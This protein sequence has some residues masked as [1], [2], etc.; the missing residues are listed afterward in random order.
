[1]PA[2]NSI[3]PDKLARLT[4]TPGA[5]LLVDVRDEVG[6]SLIPGSIV[7]SASDVATWS[8]ILIGRPSVIVDSDGGAIAQGIA[9]WLRSEGAESEAIDGGFTAWEAAGFPLVAVDRLPPR[10]IA[11]RTIWVTRARPKVDRIACPW[12]VRRFVDPDA[13]FLFV[14]PGEVL[15]VAERFGAVPFDVSAEGVFWSHRGEQCTFDVMIEEFGLAGIAPLVHLAT[16]VRGA[17]TDRLDIVPEAAGLLAIS[18]GLSRMYADDLEQLD[19]GMLV[20]DALYRWCRDARGETHDW[21]AHKPRG[22]RA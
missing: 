4:G 5:P 9:G 11:G 6:A 13:R 18:L 2:L 3:T 15:G 17:D 22:E 7:R 14:P 16:I 8:E 19:A 10:D 21:T 1:M 12:L 20:Y